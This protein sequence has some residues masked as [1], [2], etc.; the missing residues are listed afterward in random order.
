MCFVKSW[1]NILLL[2]PST[3]NRI[4]LW[5]TC[6]VTP[7]LVSHDTIAASY[8]RSSN[9]CHEEE[10]I[11][12]VS[13][14][15]GVNHSE[16]R[17]NGLD[18]NPTFLCANG[19][20]QERFSDVTITVN[21]RLRPPFDSSGLLISHFVQSNSQWGVCACACVEGNK[22]SAESREG[23]LT[24]FIWVQKSACC[25]IGMASLSVTSFPVHSDL[26]CPWYGKIPIKP[27]LRLI[28]QL[29]ST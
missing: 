8:I 26:S 7:L 14:L 20:I 17:C 28:E 4:A 21:N 25:T 12:V 11:R 1:W 29:I 18:T 19:L 2:K 5:V 24:D 3:V 27:H 9:R 6:M 22:G 23:V 15:L 10:I 16:G 13:G